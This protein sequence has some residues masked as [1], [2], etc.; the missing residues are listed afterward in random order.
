MANLPHSGMI[1]LYL[2]RQPYLVSTAYSLN[3]NCWVFHFFD[4]R[5][6]CRAFVGQITSSVCPHY[7]LWITDMLEDY[8][9]L[10]GFPFCFGDTCLPIT[11]YDSGN[12][13]SHAGRIIVRC[14]LW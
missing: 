14:R 3:V 10:L 5:H 11:S 7:G 6:I 8:V 9:K 13:T 2:A 4:A 1:E 12:V